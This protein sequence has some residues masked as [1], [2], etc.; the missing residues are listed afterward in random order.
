MKER[1]HAHLLS[2]NALQGNPLT[3]AIVVTSHFWQRGTPA[4]QPTQAESAQVYAAMV[5]V[6]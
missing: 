5:A 4:P 1:R 2:H 3:E 6:P